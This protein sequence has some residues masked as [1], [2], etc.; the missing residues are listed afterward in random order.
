MGI[1][2][3]I[4]FVQHYTPISYR[5]GRGGGGAGQLVDNFDSPLKLEFSRNKVNSVRWEFNQLS[6]KTNESVK[7]YSVWQ[8]TKKLKLNIIVGIKLTFDWR[9]IFGIFQRYQ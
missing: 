3:L 7:I 1:L 2:F 4:I 8:L 5:Q 9:V 6:K